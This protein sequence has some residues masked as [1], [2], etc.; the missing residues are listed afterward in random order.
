MIQTTNEAGSTGDD[1]V[2]QPATLRQAGNKVGEQR[3]LECVG[4]I[5]DYP[6]KR[7]V[8]GVDFHV[9]P[10]EIVGLLGPNGAGKTTTFRMAC[11]MVTPTEGKVYLRDTDVSKW[12][13]YRR[14]RNGM[15]YLPQDHSIFTRLSVEQNIHAVLEYLPLSKGER[16][17]KVDRLLEQFGLSSKRKQISSTMSGGEKRRLEIARC[18]ATDPVLILLDEPFT[19][20]DPVTIHSIQD[21]IADLRQQGISILLTDHRERETLTITDRN[22]II[23]QGTVLVSGDAETVLSNPDAQQCYFGERF[24]ASSII[25]SRDSFTNGDR[26]AA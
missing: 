3:L 14:A 11:G 21:I 5:K 8:D 16:N 25:Q 2:A 20:I 23:F 18:L 22:Y 7:A 12:P 19:G 10:G 15:G 24:D 4:L 1:T 26:D 17:D 13:M 9:M 6:G